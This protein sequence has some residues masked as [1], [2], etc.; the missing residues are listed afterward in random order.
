MRFLNSLTNRLRKRTLVKTHPPRPTTRLRLEELE[1]RAVP[2]TYV[3]TY[4][5]VSITISPG[6]EVVER[7]TVSVVP[8]GVYNELNGQTTQPPTSAPPPGGRVQVNLN[9]MQQSASLN[10]NGKATF[11]FEMF[12]PQL[13]TSQTLMVDY[14]GF[15]S[16][17][18][19][20]TGTSQTFP[21]Y[22]NYA[23][24]AF[25]GLSSLITYKEPEPVDLWTPVGLPS[26]GTV[27]GEKD[28]LIFPGGGNAF[29]FNYNSQGAIKSVQFGNE[30][31]EFPAAFA[32]FLHAYPPLVPF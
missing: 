9:N 8:F 18:I 14:G 30:P 7:V 25:F 3:N 19:N 11:T 12:W 29:A 4:P 26:M 23:N 15:T 17:N 1:D 5:N 16:G 20:W 2:T 10:Q 24:E 31:T 28:Q 22:K 13:L 6:I 27:A 32:L 21:I